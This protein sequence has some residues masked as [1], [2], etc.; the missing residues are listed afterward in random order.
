MESDSLTD[1]QQFYEG[2]AIFVTGGTGFLG[3]LLLTKLLR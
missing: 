2:K 1:I 3:H